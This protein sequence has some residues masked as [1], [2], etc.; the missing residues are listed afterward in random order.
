MMKTHGLTGTPTNKS[1]QKMRE[2]CMQPNSDHYKWY[3]GRG[4]TICPQWSDYLVFLADMGERPKGMTLD[5][6]DSNGNYEPANCRWATHT[7]Q[8]RGQRKTRWVE[9]NGEKIILA[10]YAE[11]HGI[12]CNLL[13][14]R[15]RQGMPVERVLSLGHLGRKTHVPLKAPG[16]GGYRATAAS[17]GSVRALYRKA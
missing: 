4:I 3:G 9:H 6:I 1:W 10:E 14:M 16:T 8:V 15:L 7:M 17:N 5:R 2:R 11:K 13:T 12:S